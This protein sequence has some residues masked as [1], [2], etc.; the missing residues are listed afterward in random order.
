M[1]TKHLL[2]VFCYIIWMVPLNP[3]LC[4]GNYS[5]SVVITQRSEL[6]H[7]STDQIVPNQDAGNTNPEKHKKSQLN[8]KDIQTDM[9]WIEMGPDNF[10][11]R[12]RA[13][14]IDKD[15][16][17]IIYA[18]AVDGG[19]WRSSTGG[20]SW[21]KVLYTGDAVIPWQ[22]MCITCLYQA[23]N[24]DIYFGT[25][26]IF[27]GSPGY[28]KG[29]GIWKSTKAIDSD[30]N[31]FIRLLSTSGPTYEYVSRI[32]ADIENP[33]TVYASTSHGLMVSPDG[34]A[35]W[36][37]ANGTPALL[38]TDVKTGTG[39]LV[40]SEINASTYIS[41]DEGLTFESNNT[42]WPNS[43]GGRLEFAIAPSDP[44][45]IY[46]QAAKPNGN[47]L[48]IFQSTDNGETW[49]VIGPGVG[50][51]GENSD[52]NPLETQGICADV[53]A[54]FPNDP[55]KIIVGGH[56]MWIWSNN[57]WEQIS[58]TTGAYFV[59]DG[60]HVITIHPDYQN[61]HTLYVGTDVGIYFTDNTDLIFSCLNRNYNTVQF[62][63]VCTDGEGY[64]AGGSDH[65][66]T[67]YFSF[68]ENN[69]MDATKIKNG[70]GGN[71]EMSVL[72]PRVTFASSSFGSL[73]RSIEKGMNFDDPNNPVGKYFFNNRI[74]NKYWNGLTSIIGKSDTVVAKNTPFRLWE[75]FND[76]QS[77]DSVTFINTVANM[78]LPDWELFFTDFNLYHS[79][80]TWD[81]T[82]VKNPNGDFVVTT[83]ITYLP[84]ETIYASSKIDNRKLPY[85]LTV[86]LL[87]GD[88]VRVKDV[89]QAVLAMGFKGNVWITRKSLDFTISTNLPWYPIIKP[90]LEIGMVSNLEFSADGN[91]LFFS[92]DSS[93]YRASNILYARTDTAMAATLSDINPVVN[94]AQVIDV[95]KIMTFDHTIKSIA[96]DPT[97]PENLLVTLGDW[98]YSDYIKYSTNAV[99][100]NN[101]TFVSKQGDLPVM[102]VYSSI[103]GWNDGNRAIIGTEYGVFITE[104]IT[105]SSPVWQDENINGMQN[106][107]VL[108]LRQ[109]LFTNNGEHGVSNQGVIYAATFGRGIFRSETFRGPAAID[110]LPVASAKSLVMVFPNPAKDIAYIRITLPLRSDVNITLCD[111]FGKTIKSVNFLNR[112]A[113]I[114]NLGLDIRNCAK[115]VFIARV[116]T[117][118]STAAAKFIVE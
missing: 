90:D 70:N 97:D 22:N 69:Q 114:Q 30:H 29:S 103:L 94:Y 80:F 111:I 83:H 98:G 62:T 66:G 78:L 60:Q 34:G 59:P 31:N 41:H 15:N 4:N 65:N 8:R 75:S 39:G 106:V 109:Q 19:L 56:I 57:Y 85:L 17:G 42:L 76:E 79:N 28:S 26:E 117:S 47:L 95:I 1:K 116:T 52:F 105:S 45:Y 74:L 89:V 64:T 55:Q 3:V 73:K 82:M 54:V 40:V 18:G 110:E 50:P 6:I 33:Q 7:V 92:S 84:G 115:G 5:K 14:I 11:G 48:N 108:M 16:P 72:D 99:T 88:Y 53:I 87:P 44:D 37:L 112:Q 43:P 67:L 36:G 58:E 35:N 86:S 21:N 38:S 107:P 77:I 101:P 12:T 71:C 104:D 20:L 81:T 51:N 68:G 63:S 13:L 24:G 9:T 93:L 100:S 46:C 102:Q 25:G 23:S 49:T 118:Y 27:Q 10:S 2:Y 91:Y 96:V 113:G 32:A 61:N